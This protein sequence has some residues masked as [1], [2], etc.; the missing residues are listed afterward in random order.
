ML[1][2]TSILL[3]LLSA[4]IAPAV[5]AQTTG[6][7]TSAALLDSIP[8]RA[9]ADAIAHRNGDSVVTIAGRASVSAGK[10]QSGSFDVAIQDS[11]GGIRLFSRTLSPVVHE[12]DSVKA[13]GTI[14]SY[15]GNTELVI[16][17]LSVVS[18]PPRVVL[19]HQAAVNPVAIARYSGELVSVRGRVAA[20]GRSEGGQ[21]LRL[22][23][24]PPSEHGMLTVWVPANHGALIDLS[25][26]KA[27]DSVTVTGIVTSYQDNADDPIVWQLIPRDAGD[28]QVSSRPDLLPAWALWAVI[29]VVAAIALAILSARFVARRQLAALAETEARY[30]QLLAL[31]PDAVIVHSG[32]AILFTNPA[33]AR[34]LGVANE[35]ALVGR[36]ITDFIDA[37][38]RAALTPVASSGETTAEPV[39]RA[40]ARMLSAEGH[41]VDV[42]VTT[43]PCLYHDRPAVVVLV[44]DIT[45]QLRYEHDLHALALVDELT[46]LQNRRGFALFAEQELAR[47][48]RNK[49]TPVLLFADLDDLKAINDQYGHAAGDAAI[50]QVATALKQTLR[51]TDI[52][53][54][55]SGDEFVALMTDGG[56]A[57]AEQLETRLDRAIAALAPDAQPFTVTASVGKTT[58]DPT[59]SLRDAMDRAD[60]ELYAKKKLSLR[61]QGRNTP[62]G[63]DGLGQDR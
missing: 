42:E 2:R 44:R 62:V 16:T 46:G 3:L 25:G 27:E 41:A 57:E 49:L 28:V 22:R 51:E 11:S 48:R 13:T 23:D 8:T 26:V 53:A 21:Y 33:A 5:T 59:L 18:A 10:L 17:T 40:R 12:G 39:A 30:R 1:G 50:R 31:S 60:A 20:F 4:S 56:A 6:A 35:K 58:L 34:L 61:R 19:P 36:T 54:R 14:K 37:S 52:I 45:S 55:W 43:S 47:A 15:R 24:A 29:G 7:S 38:S 63:I 9:I 32:G